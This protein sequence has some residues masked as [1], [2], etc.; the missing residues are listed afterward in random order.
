[1]KSFLS[2]LVGVAIGLVLFWGYSVLNT[3]V[4]QGLGAEIS[5]NPTATMTNAIVS[6]TVST[7]LAANSAAQ[8]RSITN[9]TI[10]G[11]GSVW[12]GFSTT[13]GVAVGKGILLT[14]SS[15][16][17]LSGDSLYTGIIY[18]IRD[19]GTSTISILQI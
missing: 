2:G 14:P 6:S 9:T 3:P 17:I 7:V 8:Y 16:L 11:S 1:M 4:R 18:G 15:T 10:G 5:G 13:T 19:A 12:I